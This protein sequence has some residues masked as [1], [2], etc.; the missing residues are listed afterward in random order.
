MATPRD[1]LLVFGEYSVHPVRVISE[2]A[3]AALF[4]NISQ[5]GNPLLQGKPTR[6]LEL[7]GAALYRKAVD[8]PS[9]LV[10]LK[11]EEPVAMHLN[12][13]ASTGGIWGGGAPPPSLAVHAAV[14]AAA[15]ASQKAF[16]PG[17]TQFAGFV[18]VKL[19]HP[20][21]VFGIVSNEAC[22]MV[23][24]AGYSQI[25]MFAVHPK[26]V[27]SGREIPGG[28]RW[29]VPFDTIDMGDASLQAELAA[30]EP[31]FAL[32]TLTPIKTMLAVFR[33]MAEDGGKVLNRSAL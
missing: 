14:G 24:K 1:A 7:L 2:D 33:K 25:F 26:T 10:V 11:G 23:A 32:C 31:G 27:E 8:V 9:S 3:T 20:G 28:S 19:P 4:A 29:E 5:R 12:W 6:D 17:T 22:K 16:E 30:T 13:D 18:G 21:A 15:V